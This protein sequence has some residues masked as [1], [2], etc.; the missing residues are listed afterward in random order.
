[1]NPHILHEKTTP[2]LLFSWQ[3]I[4]RFNPDQKSALKVHQLIQIQEQVVDEILRDHFLPLEAT[5]VIL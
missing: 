3:I 5:H 2:V 4:L 1:M